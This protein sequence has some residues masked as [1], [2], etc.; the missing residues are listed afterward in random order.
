LGDAF[1]Q[2]LIR[3]TAAVF[4]GLIEAQWIREIMLV[5]AK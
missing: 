4:V 5:K 1:R 3:V 2:A